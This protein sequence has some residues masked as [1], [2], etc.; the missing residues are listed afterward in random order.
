MSAILVAFGKWRCWGLKKFQVSFN[1]RASSESSWAKI[2][3]K[4]KIVSKQNK[5]KNHCCSCP[6]TQLTSLAREAY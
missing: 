6:G 2:K 4:I 1:Y 3:I 5:S